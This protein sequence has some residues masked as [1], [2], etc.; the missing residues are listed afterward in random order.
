MI[1]AIIEALRKGFPGAVRH[2]RTICGIQAMRLCSSELGSSPIVSRER[3]ASNPERAHI[4]AY[5]TYRH[6]FK[7]LD[8]RPPKH[9]PFPASHNEFHGTNDRSN[10]PQYKTCTVEESVSTL[11]LTK[12]FCS[13]IKA[14]RNPHALPLMGTARVALE[15]FAA[16]NARHSSPQDHQDPFPD[17]E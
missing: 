12:L 7:V 13:P 9:P 6:I 17:K 1:G 3:S 10:E 14:R 11:L 16:H 5:S 2:R 8:V 15:V 4:K